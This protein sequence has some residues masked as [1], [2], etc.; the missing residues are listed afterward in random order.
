MFQELFRTL[1]PRVCAALIVLVDVMNAKCQTRAQAQAD[2]NDEAIDL[3]RLRPKVKLGKVRQIELTP[4]EP[5]SKEKTAQITSCI[6]RLA[7]IESPDFGLSAT[8]SGQ[9]FLPL[10][11]QRQ[12]HAMVL[13]DHRLKSSAALR[14]LVEIGPEA[15]PFLLDALGDKTPTKLKLEHDSGFGAMWLANELWGNPVNELE[16]KSLRQ[17]E[18]N[19]ETVEDR[20]HIG[21]YTVKIGDVCLV[22]IGQIVGR[23]YQAVRFQ[24]TAC[25][26]INS[27]TDDATLRE[28]V[29]RVW[30]S[31]DPAR[32]VFDSLLLD[33]A[34]EGVFQGPSLDS[35]GLGSELQIESA[36]RLLFYYPKETTALIAERLRSLDVKKTSAQ[37]FAFA[38]REVANGLST[39]DFIKAVS[40]CREPHIRQAIRDIFASTDD[41]DLLLAALA[42]I[43]DGDRNL[44]RDRLHV[45]LQALPAQE[46]GAYGDG[47][48]LLVAAGERLGKEAAPAFERYL[49]GASAQRCHSATQ[50]LAETKGDWCIAVLQRLLDD[51]RPVGGYSYATHRNDHDRRLPIRVCD[52]AAEALQAH[53]PDLKFALEGEHQDLDKQI[54]KIRDKL[55]GKR[56]RRYF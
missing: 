18:G 9:A 23:G 42:A 3:E 55:A 16:M 47:Y 34:T 19:D 6:A 51:R 33:Y 53:R 10:P 17:P 22:A 45:F 29:R 40:W 11:S 15:L 14:N 8:M 49:K 38:R 13:T 30:T 35:W 43:D 24:P 50:A 31:G 36:M 48:N 27:P 2:R 25:I 21:S 4:R 46:H 7:D 56:Q 1:A 26:V 37:G 41:L 39:R 5:L 28:Q 44:I 54:K 12:S 52:A 20:K 32:K